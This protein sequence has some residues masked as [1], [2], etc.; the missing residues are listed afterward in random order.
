V[1]ALGVAV[2][3]TV[4]IAPFDHAIASELGDPAYRMEAIAL[5]TSVTG[6]AKGLTGRALPNVDARHEF[7]FG[8]ASTKETGNSYPFRRS[9][10][11]RGHRHVE[12]P[13]RGEARLP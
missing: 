4:A 10:A 2:V 7:S 3:A 8:R 12:R 6:L 1:E 9:S 13:R 5:A 11:G